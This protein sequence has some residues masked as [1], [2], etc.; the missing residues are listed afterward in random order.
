MSDGEFTSHATAT[1]TVVGVNDA[2]VAVAQSVSTNEDTALAITLAGTDV[3]DDALTYSIA[4]GP[5]KGTLS[6]SG[7]DWTYTPNLNANGPDEFTFLVN[8][9]TVDSQ[10]VTVSINIAPVNDAPY[11]RRSIGKYR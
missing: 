9:G 8:D 7:A 6:G 2:P 11:R 1:I 5:T 10:A 3:E 4:S